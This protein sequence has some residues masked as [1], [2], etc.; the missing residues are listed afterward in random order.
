MKKSVSCCSTSVL[1][2]PKVRLPV[3]ERGDKTSS[4]PLSLSG[5][6]RF[7]NGFI[8]CGWH[9]PCCIEYVHTK[10]TRS[11][12]RQRQILSSL[13]LA[14]NIADISSRVFT[15]QSHR[16]ISAAFSNVD[17]I[18]IPSLTSDPLPSF[19][20]PSSFPFDSIRLF[21]RD[22][23]GTLSQFPEGAAVSRFYCG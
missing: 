23:S 10:E 21:F 20:P 22:C 13:P 4:L 18:I 6:D 19:L 14:D 7:F 5:V 15:P 8:G 12:R 3:S 9:L 2:T 16:A 11:M 17:G 1:P